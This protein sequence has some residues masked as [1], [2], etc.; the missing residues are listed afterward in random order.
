MK[1]HYK[2]IPYHAIGK[3]VI[4]DSQD[5]DAMKDYIERLEWDLYCAT[6]RIFGTIP[7]ELQKYKKAIDK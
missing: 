2:R 7:A 1:H 3:K 4:L 5:F 6:G